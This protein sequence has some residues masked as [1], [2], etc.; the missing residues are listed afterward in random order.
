MSQTQSELYDKI[1]RISEIDDIVHRATEYPDYYDD[2]NLDELGKERATLIQSIMDLQA[3]NTEFSEN[4]LEA[5]LILHDQPYEEFDFGSDAENKAYI[6]QIDRGLSH[7]KQTCI[8]L[9]VNVW[10]DWYKK[11]FG[12]E[13][14]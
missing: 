14:P 8:K 9:D 7:I 5:Y 11:V 3:R 12:K 2:Y 4:L 10:K 13:H 6:E 1:E